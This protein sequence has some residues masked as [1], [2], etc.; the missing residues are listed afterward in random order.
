MQGSDKTIHRDMIP[1]CARAAWSGLQMVT[2]AFV[3]QK[4]ITEVAL[5]VDLDHL[6]AS[7]NPPRLEMHT[8]IGNTRN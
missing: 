4:A 5:V 7:E 3:M 8:F 2:L 1:R 6:V